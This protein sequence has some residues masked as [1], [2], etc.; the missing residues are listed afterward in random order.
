MATAKISVHVYWQPEAGTAGRFRVAEVAEPPAADQQH[1]VR[2]Q[3]SMTDPAVSL[4][5]DP[6]RYQIIE[7]LFPNFNDGRGYSLA[8]QLRTGHGYTGQ[9]RATGDIRIDQADMLVRCG[10]DQLELAADINLGELE[11]AINA[12]TVHYQSGITRAHGAGSSV[13]GG[14]PPRNTFSEK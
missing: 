4:P 3:L 10:F 11:D 5:A 9:L 2:L 14:A 1:G 8:R 7:I 12:V 13:T 6:D